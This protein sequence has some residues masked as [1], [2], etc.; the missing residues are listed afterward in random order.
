MSIEQDRRNVIKNL[1][2]NFTLSDKETLDMINRLFEMV[3]LN[4]KLI[5]MQDKRIKLLEQA[6]TSK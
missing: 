6:S 3:V 5:N 1:P 2:D 4:N